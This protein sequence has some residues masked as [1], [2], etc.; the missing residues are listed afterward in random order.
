MLIV[1]IEI[2][3]IVLAFLKVDIKEKAMRDSLPRAIAV[4]IKFIGVLCSSIK[5][6]LRKQR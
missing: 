3:N 5:G 2:M 4:S 6:R 1:L